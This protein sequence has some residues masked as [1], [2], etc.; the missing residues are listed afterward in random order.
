MGTIGFC[1]V[2]SERHIIGLV[3]RLRGLADTSWGAELEKWCE[4]GQ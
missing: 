3:Q 4:F 1:L 2:G